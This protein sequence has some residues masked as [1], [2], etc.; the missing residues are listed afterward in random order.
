MEI[1]MKKTILTFILLLILAP[2]HLLAQIV[3]YHPEVDSLYSS[4]S[5]QPY[6]KWNVTSNGTTDSLS[7]EV[8]HSEDEGNYSKFTSSQIEGEFDNFLIL[9][10]NNDGSLNYKVQYSIGSPENDY[11]EIPSD[12]FYV[13]DIQESQ[14]VHLKFIVLDETEEIES[15]NLVVEH[16]IGLSVEENNIPSQ[17]SL[18]QNYPNPFNPSTLITFELFETMNISLVIY[19]LLGREVDRLIDFERLPYGTHQRVWEPD[20]DVGSGIYF[21]QIRADGQIK[22]KKMTLIK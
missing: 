17:F 4:T 19:D 6:Y 14:F 15:L 22:T 2:I 8:F 7:I 16:Q 5:G 1:N 18:S 3:E 21:Y 11:S 20:S 12:S 10:E 13:I 9:I